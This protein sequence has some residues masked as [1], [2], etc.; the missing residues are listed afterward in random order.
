M[1]SIYDYL[2]IGFYL[3]FLASMGFVFKRFNSGTND[4]FAG[5]FKQAWWLLGASSFISNFSCWTF[6]GA[7]NI[8]YTYGLLVFG[9]YI[10]DIVGFIVSAAWF[11]PR[12]RQLRLVTAVDAIRMRYGRFTEQLFNWLWFFASLATA[13]VSLV[14]LSIILSSAFHLPQIPVILV[15]GIVVVLIALVGGN[16]A[17]A[18][19]DFVQLL[20]L[21][22]VTVVVAVLTLIRVGG[23]GAFI[24]QIPSGHW[25]MFRPAGSIPYDWLFLTTAL[26]KAAY[27]KNNITYSAKYIAAKDGANARRSAL[28]PLIGYCVLPIFWFIPPL[29]A[30]TLVPDLASTS[31]MKIPGEA[32]YVAV[33]LQVLPHGLLGLMIAAMFSATIAN[34]DVG[35]NKNAGFFVKNFYQPMLRSRASD[36]ELY[37]VGEIATFVFGLIIVG[38]AMQLVLAPGLSLFDAFL[39]LSAYLGMP[40]AIP[41]FLGM[42][43][44]R[45]P[46]WAAWGAA[47]FGVSLTVFFFNFLPSA[48]GRA[49][50]EPLVGEWSYR[51]AITNRFVMTNLICV[52]LTSLFF[53]ATRWFYREP[54]GS[55]Y[56]AQVAG[57]F[58]RMNTAVDFEQEVGGDNTASQARIIGIMASIYGS[59]VL[60][61]TL[62]PN[63]LAGRLGIL[64]CATTLLGVGFGLQAY[65]RRLRCPAAATPAR[66]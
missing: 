48:T 7:A 17:V 57:F 8:A 58:S 44:R 47:L 24:D 36:R 3:V 53:V 65:G 56:D 20:L 34:L 51:Y 63:P 35:L 23:V 40:I 12:F 22:S 66:P 6:T 19:S 50:F 4:Y 46:R 28:I 60:L 27:E 49:W 14:G 54:T 13:A 15:T 45:T 43:V 29:A 5:G 18:A 16:W 10:I 9:V 37:V 62:I 59:F 11:A 26:F 33:C 41:L 21:L 39:Y 2:I 38:G 61:L 31:P 30:F 1:L 52:P 42:L 32:S 55:A 64:A 25:Q